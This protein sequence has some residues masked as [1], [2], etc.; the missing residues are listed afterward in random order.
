MVFGCETLILIGKISAGAI[1]SA[2]KHFYIIPLHV[3]LFTTCFNSCSFASDFSAPPHNYGGQQRVPAAGRHFDV[4]G[5]WEHKLPGASQPG[6]SRQ[7]EPPEQPQQP[8]LHGGQQPPQ[9]QSRGQLAQHFGLVRRLHRLHDESG[10]RAGLG[11]LTQPRATYGDAAPGLH[12]WRRR[13]PR[14]QW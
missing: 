1:N 5:A 13:K 10:R 3:I 14:P 8:Q 12:V 6:G 11:R 4:V 7:P 9:L 2:F